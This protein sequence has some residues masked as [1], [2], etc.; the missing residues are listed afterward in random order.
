[1][2]SVPQKHVGWQ[3]QRRAIA[4]GIL[5]W[6]WGGGCPVPRARVGDQCLRDARTRL[7]GAQ[8]SS[9]TSAV[10]QELST[11]NME[12]LAPC[13]GPAVPLRHAVGRILPSSSA[14]CLPPVS[15]TGLLLPLLS[16]HSCQGINPICSSKA[17]DPLPLLRWSWWGHRQGDAGGVEQTEPAPYLI[18]K[19]LD[20]G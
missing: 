18:P 6:V 5:L 20:W 16:V 17:L 15:F 11:G 8:C 12:L 19:P 2:G 13:K 9:S 7:D 10:G 14:P 4:V 3:S 1:M